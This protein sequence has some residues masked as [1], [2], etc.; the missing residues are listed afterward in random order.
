MNKENLQKLI[1]HLEKMPPKAFNLA[2]WLK[3]EEDGISSMLPFD[4]SGAAAVI[5]TQLS[6]KTHECGTVGC[7]AG[8]AALLAESEGKARKWDDVRSVA[9][10]WLSAEFME[11]NYLFIPMSAAQEQE[12][13]EMER[14]AT[15][16]V[17]LDKVSVKRVIN[18]LKHL[19]ATGEVDWS[20]AGWTKR[21]MGNRVYRK[22]Q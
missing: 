22:E 2:Y 21:E 17:L 4:S 8:Y 19:L 10:Q 16:P 11:T 14:S 3:N 5:E 13:G 15:I 7:I 6:S 12:E 1:T 18:V 9:N 20:K